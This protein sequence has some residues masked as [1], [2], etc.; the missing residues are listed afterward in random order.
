MSARD[1]LAQD[2]A[3]ATLRE[4]LRAGETPETARRAAFK[5]AVAVL[6]AGV[7]LDAGLDDLPG[8]AVRIRVRG[9]R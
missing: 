6:V 5:A 7:V 9:G 2:V 1:E 8:L 4:A 3:V